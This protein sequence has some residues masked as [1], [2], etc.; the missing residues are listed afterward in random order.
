MGEQREWF[1]EME[2]APGEDSLKIIEVNL[3]GKAGAGF[4]RIEFN[5]ESSSVGTVASHAAEKL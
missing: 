1:L 5:F 4:E 3:V 2:S